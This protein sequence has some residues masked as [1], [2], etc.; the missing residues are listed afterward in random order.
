MK[1]LI[2]SIILLIA[3]IVLF[4]WLIGMMKAAA[5]D[6]TK[7]EDYDPTDNYHDSQFKNKRA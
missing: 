5:K 1:I 3:I 6:N 4:Y 7:N 2:V